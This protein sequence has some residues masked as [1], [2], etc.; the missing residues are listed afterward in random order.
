MAPSHCLYQYWPVTNEILWHSTAGDFTRKTQDIHPWY[1]FAYSRLMM[2]SLHRNIFRVT[3]HLCG[4]IHRSPVNSPHKGQWRGALMFSLICVWINGWVNN[5]EAGDLRRY[6]AHYGV[7]VMLELH[8]PGAAELTLKHWIT[9]L[10]T[11]II[12]S[13]VRLK[14]LWCLGWE[15]PSQLANTT[16]L[17]GMAA[18]I[19][20]ASAAKVLTVYDSHIFFIRNESSSL[21]LLNVGKMYCIFAFPLINFVSEFYL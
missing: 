17:H 6:R 2:T 14:P 3:G 20:R 9:K 11:W 8:L 4:E 1:E 18:C 16:F 5:R 12:S 21:Q 7:I 13:V 15:I 10:S 19:V